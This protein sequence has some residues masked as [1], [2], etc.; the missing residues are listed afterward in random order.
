MR[1]FR[2]KSEDIIIIEKIL[3]S[4]TPKFNFVVYVI[5]ESKN[6]DDLSLDELQSSLLVEAEVKRRE[7]TTNGI[8]NN[9]NHGTVNLKEEEEDKDKE[10]IAQKVINGDLKTN[11]L[12]VGQ[13]QEKGYEIFIKNGVCRVHDKKIRL[14]C[15]GQHDIEPEEAST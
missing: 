2:D 11:L 7:T 13:L 1:M 8:S 9:I 5:E 6:I 3:R 12:S 15:S 14:D 4:L 10:A